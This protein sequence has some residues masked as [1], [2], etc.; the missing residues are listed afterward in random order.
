MDT[1]HALLSGFSHTLL[2]KLNASAQLYS[3]ELSRKECLSIS[4]PIYSLQ[5]C[6]YVKICYFSIFWDLNLHHM[7]PYRQNCCLVNFLHCII[8]LRAPLL[9]SNIRCSS[10]SSVFQCRDPLTKLH[11][12]VLPSQKIYL[13]TNKIESNLSVST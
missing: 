10:K 8:K 2:T 9:I 4:I 13:D 11:K 12:L 6:T 7:V 5:D 1:Q 3:A